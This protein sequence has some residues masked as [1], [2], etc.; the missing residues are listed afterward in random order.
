MKNR[1]CVARAQETKIL[2]MYNADLEEHIHFY[3]VESA[4]AS[5]NLTLKP[6]TTEQEGR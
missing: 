4:T 2:D 1:V 5:D 6:Y 3:R